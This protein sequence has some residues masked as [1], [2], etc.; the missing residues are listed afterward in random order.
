VAIGPTSVA[1]T[2]CTLKRVQ[3]EITS[4]TE[5]AVTRGTGRRVSPSDVRE[6]KDAVVSVKEG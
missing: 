4:K 3:K 6:W 2:E 1:V 5:E